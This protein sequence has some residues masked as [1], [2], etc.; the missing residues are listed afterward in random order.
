MRKFLLTFF[1]LF[2]LA[3]CAAAVY[4]T[5]PPA[6]EAPQGFVI[7]PSSMVPP[8]SPLQIVSKLEIARA[9]VGGRDFLP[10]TVIG[11]QRLVWPLFAVPAEADVVLEFNH[12]VDL[13]SLFAQTTVLPERTV[14]DD[15][16]IRDPD[17]PRR[18]TLTFDP[19][20]TTQRKV[21]LR[22]R[23]GVAASDES[24]QP[25]EHEY[26]LVLTAE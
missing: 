10:P 16:F 8:P 19:P 9:I 15:F 23:S 5:K 22:I 11:Q 13:E 21:T 4:V 1:G 7:V 2:A 17:N 18:V 14:H 3:V 12:E 25:S 24:A 6:A 26:M 20:L